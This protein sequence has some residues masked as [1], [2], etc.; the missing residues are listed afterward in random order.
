MAKRTSASARFHEA[1]GAM[2]AMRAVLKNAGVALG[3]ERRDMTLL[4]CIQKNGRQRPCF[5][6]L[7]LQEPRRTQD[8]IRPELTFD[9]YDADDGNRLLL[10]TAL[11]WWGEQRVWS[12]EL[13][14]TG[15]DYRG[16]KPR[17]PRWV[18]L[19]DERIPLTEMVAFNW[20]R[21]IA[22]FFVSL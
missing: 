3:D 12:V 2:D 14:L 22:A 16:L 4:G 9:M 7:C 18:H 5:V 8:W 20:V 10:R 6:R 1:Y 13:V 17:L 15:E 21:R 19:N 11:A